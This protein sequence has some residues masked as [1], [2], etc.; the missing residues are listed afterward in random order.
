MRPAPRTVFKLRP[1]ES[2]AP[3]VAHHF[4][5]D[6]VHPAHCNHEH[7]PEQTSAQQFQPN[8]HEHEGPREDTDKPANHNEPTHSEK[9]EA[10]NRAHED[11]STTHKNEPPKE[12]NEQTAGLSLPEGI[13][14]VGRCIGRKSDRKGL[15]NK[16]L[17]RA[18]PGLQL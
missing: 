12:P 6:F 15:Q 7:D 3:E 5:Q 1:G 10:G 11:A 4:V 9:P 14:G 17:I 8:R 18:P 2:P 16:V 13:V